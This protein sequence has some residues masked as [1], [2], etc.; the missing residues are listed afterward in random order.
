M[1]TI[2]I[3]DG[4]QVTM[5]WAEIK[6][7]LN[8]STKALPVLEVTNVGAT[9]SFAILVAFEKS[10]RYVCELD[11]ASSD[12]TDWDTNVKPTATSFKNPRATE[13][14]TSSVSATTSTVTLLAANSD[15]L[16]ATVHND[17]NKALYLKLGSG[18]STSDFTV[19]VPRKGYYEVPY[20]YTGIL[21]GVW[22][23][24]ASGNAR[25]TEVA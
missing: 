12:Y 21:T 16:G 18:A 14:T 4:V 2:E 22:A 17:S 5:D 19:D 7:L 1:A 3:T 23:S 15:R 8:G 11:P 6:P 20:Q 13:S 25:V 9:K 10:V 24:G